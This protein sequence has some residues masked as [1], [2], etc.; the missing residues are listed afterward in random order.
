MSDDL[1]IAKQY[2][3]TKNNDEFKIQTLYDLDHDLSWDDNIKA[4]RLAKKEKFAKKGD[5][6]IITAG[7]PFGHSGATNVLRIASVDRY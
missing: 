7:V 6:V 5:R 3:F 4:R 2:V 1:E